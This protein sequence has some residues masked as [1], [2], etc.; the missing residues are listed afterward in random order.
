[1]G[2]LAKALGKALVR[3]AKSRQ[4]RQRLENRQNQSI[5]KQKQVNNSKQKTK[6]SKIIKTSGVPLTEESEKDVLPA[7][8]DTRKFG[9]DA[10]DDRTLLVGEGNF[11]FAAAIAQCLGSASTMTATSL[12]SLEVL[13]TKYPGVETHLSLLRDY[14]ATILHEIDGTKLHKHFYKR[15]CL[16]TFHK[17]IF[18][19]PHSGAGIKDQD[20]NIRANQ[21]LLQAFFQSAVQV[22]A[23]NGEIFVSLKTGMPYDEWRV[24][25]QALGLGLV[26]RRSFQF[27]PVEYPGYEHRRT[28]GFQEGLSTR[29]SEDLAKHPC[30]TFV[31]VRQG[32]EEKVLQLAKERKRKQKEEED[33]LDL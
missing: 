32:E 15:K 27:S 16:A 6:I 11:S 8:T 4:Q 7:A 2:R 9:L 10:S 21:E 28:I 19:F 20:R 14:E 23:P 18:N 29:H 25:K 13:T 3:D 30:R 12:D 31:F 26:T 1:M 5:Q 17:I 22:L 24:K 33:G